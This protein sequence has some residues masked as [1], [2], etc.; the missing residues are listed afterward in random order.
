MTRNLISE[1]GLLDKNFK[2]SLIEITFT[3]ATRK[4]SINKNKF[5]I[6]EMF[7]HVITKQRRNNMYLTTAEHN[8][9]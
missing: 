1:F 9:E 7:F 5:C 4:S 6:S 8:I 3:A 2:I